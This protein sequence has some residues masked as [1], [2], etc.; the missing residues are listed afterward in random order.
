MSNEKNKDFNAMLH[1][2]KG[3]PKI[4]SI[5][6]EKSFKR[7]GGSR[8]L[9]SPPIEYDEV[10]RRVPRG[11]LLT[12][13]KIREYLARR[14]GAD[15]TDPLT[16][17][18]FVA[19]AAWASHQRNGDETP[20][21]RTLKACGELNPRYPE[22]LEAQKQKLKAEGHKIVQKGSKNPRYF[23]EDYENSLFDLE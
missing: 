22:G 19:I 12:V 21:W 1:D 20:Y 11:K 5:K 2:S 23:V 14:S 7:Y 3:M 16:A 18:I 15:F 17:G 6:D 4:I 13:G 9:L 10:M 8:M